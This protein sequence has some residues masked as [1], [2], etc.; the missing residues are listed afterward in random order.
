MAAVFRCLVVTM[1]L[2]TDRA[3]SCPYDGRGCLS[4]DFCLLCYLSCLLPYLRMIPRRGEYR[5][6]FSALALS[7]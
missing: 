7:W 2:R 5:R 3:D 1:T 6:Q 4:V